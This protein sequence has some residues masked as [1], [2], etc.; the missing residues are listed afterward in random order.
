M[1]IQSILSRSILVC[2]LFI[3]ATLHTYS[4]WGPIAGLQGEYSS[5]IWSSGQDLMAQILWLLSSV[6][7]VGS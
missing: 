1:K 6:L 3:A 4:Q 5:S 7:P 2:S